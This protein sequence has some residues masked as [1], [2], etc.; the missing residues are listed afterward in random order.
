MMSRNRREFLA[1]V[2]KGMLIASVGP[3]MAANLGVAPA[4]AGEGNDRLT[5]GNREPLV[6]LLQET[7]PDKLLPILVSKLNA[8]LP[9]NELV[10]A[11]ALANARTFGGHDYDGYHAFMALTPAYHMAQET[12]AERRALPV[13]KVLHRNS[14]FIQKYGGRA[15]EALHPVEPAEL[16]AGKSGGEALQEATR[17]ADRAAAERTL[18]ALAR[19]P[20]GDAYNAVQLCVQDDID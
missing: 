10:A 7:P 17:R 3:S 2:G 9:L 20:G 13:L 1:N 14:R 19:S 15:N 11:A 5:F 8:G 4:F 12:P 18:A 16:P 6:A